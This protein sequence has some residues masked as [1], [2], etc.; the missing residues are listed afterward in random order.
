[1]RQS[2]VAI[3]QSRRRTAPEIL[4]IIE[5]R[6]L[7]YR[8]KGQVPNAVEIQRRLAALLKPADVPSERTIRN[9]A[10]ELLD[11]GRPWRPMA[12]T[13]DA[14]LV[15][16]TLAR[17]IEDTHGART[18]LTVREAELIAAIRGGSGCD[19]LVAYMLARAYLNAESRN[20]P[21]EAL[22][23]DGLLAFGPWR[24]PEARRAYDVALGERWI[25]PPRLWGR[26]VRFER[27]RLLVNVETEDAAAVL[28]DRRA[29]SQQ[30]IHRAIGI[31]GGEAFAKAKG[32]A[33]NSR[34]TA[35]SKARA[36]ARKAGTK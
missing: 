11:P 36:G 7:E 26:L 33:A 34:P 24:G 10:N 32:R 35:T 18:Q 16:P 5:E 2:K 28:N 1:M 31:L 27:D 3:R 15:L 12:S 13:V 23:L 29:R 4:Q 30:D 14:S 6:A 21:D 8:L 25:E 20:D 22:R 9:V 19:P 17:L